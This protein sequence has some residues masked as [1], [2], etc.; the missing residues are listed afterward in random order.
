MKAKIALQ[1]SDERDVHS[2]N[3]EDGII[4][5]I[6]SCLGVRQGTA[7][8]FGAWDGVHLSNTAALRGKGWTTVLIEADAERVRQLQ[9]LANERTF[10]VSAMVMPDGHSSLDSILDRQGIEHVDFLC[11]DIDGDDI[12]MLSGL[13]RRPRVICIEFNPTIPPP[14][15]FV[16]PRGTCKGSSLSSTCEVAS[17]LDYAL[18][19]ATYCNAFFVRREDTDIIAPVD[20]L[21]AYHSVERPAIISYY[22]GE[23]GIPNGFLGQYRHGWSTIP[24]YVPRIP[25]VLRGW[26][27][28]LP[29]VFLAY[30]YSACVSPLFYVASLLREGARQVRIR[31]R[32]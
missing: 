21:F 6:F 11:I 26:P 18:V 29:K 19:Y 25:A 24:V 8:E 7:V 3:G 22:D 10:V 12:H 13:R 4:D 14:L 20:P 16:N 31:L 9:T 1:K 2:Q 30:L 5:K 15:A 23:F 27:P 28:T 32:S 17:R